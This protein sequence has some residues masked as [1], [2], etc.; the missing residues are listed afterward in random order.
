[1]ATLE[2]RL[3]DAFQAVGN[4]VQVIR[5]E[6][7]FVYQQY[8]L[9][10]V[11]LGQLTMGYRFTR[12][13]RLVAVEYYA[14]S[15]SSGGTSTAELRLTAGGS[16]IAGSSGTVAVSPSTVTLTTP[17]DFARK[18]SL[19]IQCTAIGTGT[20]GSGLAAYLIG[21]TIL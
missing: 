14:E 3:T 7:E 6:D 5:E 20:I 18:A 4:D 12:P 13:F 15:N 2:S 19:F 21:D 11:G 10:V 17:V 16:A 9:R 1:M 8:G